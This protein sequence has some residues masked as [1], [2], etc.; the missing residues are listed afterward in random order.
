MLLPS[1]EQIDFILSK[2]PDRKNSSTFGFKPSEL[3]KQPLYNEHKVTLM[4]GGVRSGKTRISTVKLATRYWLGKLFWIIGPDYD[5]CREEFAFLVD[6]FKALGVLVPGELHFPS[7]DQCRMMVSPDIVIETKSAKYPEKIAGRACDGII[8][9]EPGQMSLDIFLRSIER[10][11]DM[12]GWL[13]MAGTL[14]VSSDWFADKFNE[15]QNPGN[16]DGG[17]SIA[18]PTWANTV[19][20]PGGRTDPKIIQMENSFGPDRFQ[21]RCGGVPLRP[22][23]VV[24]PEFKALHHVGRFPLNPGE[25]V[26]VC[27]DPGYF[28]SAYAVEFLQFIGDDIY[29]FDE[30]Y[31]QHLGTDQI[32]QLVTLKPYASLIKGGA[33]DVASK[34]HHGAS[35]DYQI[36]A[37]ENK[38]S[39]WGGINL[40]NRRIKP[41]SDGVNRLRTFLRPH[42]LTGQPQLHID[43]RCKGLLGELGAG[44]FPEGITMGVWKMKMDSKGNIL[45]SEPDEKNN[46]GCKALIYG[47]VARKG[48]GIQPKKRSVSQMS[49]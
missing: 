13:M 37:T 11:A 2:I 21:E 3:Q 4:T 8:L 5:Q 35:P 22:R 14:E 38:D 32:V 44:K 40:D 42:P 41:I 24:L 45:S 29:V 39:N 43:S 19:I 1:K 18:M 17:I 25:D 23:G 48:L 7:R 28:P 46:H 34:Q 47:I 16:L 6:D 9:C 26:F 36:W 31:E 20:F 15:Y 27:I 49:I 10:L 30:I 33:I 12:D